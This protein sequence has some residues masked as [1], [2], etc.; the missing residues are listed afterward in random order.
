MDSDKLEITE[1]LYRY[2]ELIDSGDFEG[3]AGADAIAGLFATT[4]R[5]F[6]EHGNREW[7]RSGSAPKGFES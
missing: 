6:P 7:R 1:L 3:V 5:R 4:T 2:A